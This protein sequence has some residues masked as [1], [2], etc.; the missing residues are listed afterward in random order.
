MVHPDPAKTW[1]H[2][3][4]RG[5]GYRLHKDYPLHWAQLLAPTTGVVTTR[6]QVIV[7]MPVFPDA[8]DNQRYWV[9]LRVQPKPQAFAPVQSFRITAGSIL[10]VAI[11]VSLLMATLLAHDISAPI[12]LLTDRVRRLSRGEQALPVPISSNDEVGELA[13]AFEEMEEALREHMERL[14]RLDIAGRRITAT[15][16]RDSILRAVTEALDILFDAP[17][18]VVRSTA[19]QDEAEPILVCVG[20]RGHLAAGA[21]EEAERA[22]KAAAEENTWQPARIPLAD[23][24][25]IY[26]CCAPM[27][28]ASRLHG[29]LEIYGLH[30][31]VIDPAEGNLLTSLAMQVAAALENADLY[32]QLEQQRERLRTLVEQLIAVQEE[33]RRVVAYDIHD[34]LIQRLVGARLY[35]LSLADENTLSSDEDRRVLERAIEHLS[36]AIVEARHTIEGLR[37]ALLDELGLVPALEQYALELSQQDGWH[38]RIQAPAHMERLP[39]S[40]EITAFRIAQEALN[41]IHKYAQAQNVHIRLGVQDDTLLLEIR[42]DG[43]GFDLVEARGRKQCVGLMSMQERARLLG[44]SCTIQSTPGKGTTVS[45]SLPVHIGEPHMEGGMWS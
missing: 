30:P 25:I 19:P 18:K 21:S 44:G 16:D 20:E 24:T 8:A 43:V 32:R 4:D 45:A 27:R 9:L 31:D 36:A 35:L 22:R 2:P 15:L 33:E 12:R 1:G 7:H 6:D 23:G 29:W 5:T 14:A 11:M 34:G 28:S 39:D 26:M 38:L 3:W 37:P 42:D 17:C 40:V 10:L 41:N 13:R